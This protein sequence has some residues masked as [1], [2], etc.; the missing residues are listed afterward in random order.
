MTNWYPLF[1][2]LIVS[3]TCAYLRTSLKVW[4]IAGFAALLAASW[5][6]GSHW[7]AI[8]LTG[9]AFALITVPLNLPDFRRQ[10]L[11]AP[12]LKVYQ[13]ITPRLSDTERV[14]LEAGTVGFEGELFSGK[15][16]WKILLKQP[17][18][19]LST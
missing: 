11:T 15:P 16:D 2:V 6:A 5:L 1:A 10:K 18:P 8:A 17:A 7:L 12:L 14:A 3:L 9:A 4:T 19:Q 13:K